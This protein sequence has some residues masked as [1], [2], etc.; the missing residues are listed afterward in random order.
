MG[1]CQFLVPCRPDIA[2]S[3]NRLARSLAKTFKSNI[4]ASKRLLRYLCGTVDLGLKLQ[5]QNREC[6]TL[7]VSNDNEWAGDRPTRK[8]RVIVGDHAGW[9]FCSAPVHEHSRLLHS[10]HAKQ[11]TS[12]PQQ[13]VKY[14]QACS[15]LVATREHPIAFRQVWRH[16][17][18]KQERSAATT[19]S[20]CA[21]FVATAGDS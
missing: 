15:W 7:T 11:S 1:K 6:S 10:P 5:M 2:F 13:P 3:T 19:S 9:S 21:V 8:S 18:C 16:W 20:G 4:I 12:Q 17:S 14:I